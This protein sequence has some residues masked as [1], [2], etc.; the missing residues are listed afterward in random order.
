MDV[1]H[2]SSDFPRLLW[3][4]FLHFLGNNHGIKCPPNLAFGGLRFL[5]VWTSPGLQWT[6]TSS[7]AGPTWPKPNPSNSALGAPCGTRRL[8]ASLGAAKCN[9][10]RLTVSRSHQKT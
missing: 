1:F 8:P 10:S 5:G 6:G 3:R 4:N 2:V 9:A 7:Q